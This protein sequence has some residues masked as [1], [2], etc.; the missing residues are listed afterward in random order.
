MGELLRRALNVP[1]A[2]DSRIKQAMPDTIIALQTGPRRIQY[3]STIVKRGEPVL[4]ATMIRLITKAEEF[5]DLIEKHNYR[6]FDQVAEATK[7]NVSYVS[8]ISR[9]AWLSPRIKKSIHA[10]EHPTSI[11]AK[12]LS[13][14]DF[15][16]CWVAQE[17]QFF[18]G[19][20][21]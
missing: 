8:R 21:Q 11:S 6:R 3:R 10:G 1:P 2:R 5:N 15:P 7:V 13:I 12:A 4:D 14:W 19:E 9:L 17:K 18:S 16:F 20:L